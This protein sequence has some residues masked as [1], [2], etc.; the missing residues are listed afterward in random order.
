MPLDPASHPSALLK[1]GSRSNGRKRGKGGATWSR[2]FLWRY[3]D[4]LKL[5]P[6]D[7][8]AMYQFRKL[9]LF[10]YM[11]PPPAPVATSTPCTELS[12]AV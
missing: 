7:Y 6:A 8:C 10:W 1:F 12:N 4:R 5:A 9:S 2:P 11:K 3:A